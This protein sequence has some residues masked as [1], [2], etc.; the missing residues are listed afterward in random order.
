M[1]RGLLL[2]LLATGERAEADAA[3]E[4]YIALFEAWR[5]ARRD[6]DT[7]AARTATQSV[8]SDADP[9]AVVALLADGRH[10]PDWAPALTDCV[11]VA[12]PDA[13]TVNYLRE[14]APER[15]THAY[16]RVI[17]RPGGGSVIVLTLPVPHGGD[18]T[19]V[20]AVAHDELAALATLLTA[21]SAR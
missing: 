1:T 11:A 9:A 12:A 4:Q 14:N 17:P 6:R 21:L 3:V 18:A 8:E 20:A 13:G 16:L 19:E 7:R 2:D 5:A 10:V 15:E